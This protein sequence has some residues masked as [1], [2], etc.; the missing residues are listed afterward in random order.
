M[1]GAAAGSRQRS[2][3]ALAAVHADPHVQVATNPLAQGR[4]HLGELVLAG[5][6]GA[7]PSQRVVGL[8]SGAFQKAMMASPLYL[9]MV[10]PFQVKYHL[11]GHL[12]PHNVY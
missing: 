12:R 8:D 4:S 6:R 7:H 2:A 1:V 9:S 3:H 11:T 5:Q 10:P